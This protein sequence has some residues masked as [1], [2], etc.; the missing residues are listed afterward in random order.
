M[1]EEELKLLP[2]FFS[3][4][5]PVV[6]SGL[7]IEL[8][9]QGHVVVTPTYELDP[10]YVHKTVRFYDDYVYI[11]GEGFHE[12]LVEHRLPE[13]F[14]H[15]VRIEQENLA[16]FLTYELASLRRYATKIDPVS[17]SLKRSIWLPHRLPAMKI[18]GGIIS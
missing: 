4:K 6:K 12:L 8:D 18:R 11:E 3:A 15:P 17:S 1:N 10:N 14:K 13:R 2:G 7:Q 16:L 5:N 9:E